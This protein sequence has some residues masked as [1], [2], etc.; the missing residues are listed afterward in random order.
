MEGERSC[1]SVRSLEMFCQGGML[2]KSPIYLNSE[3]AGISNG[4]A[5]SN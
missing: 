2:L 5:G 3:L 4:I 1:R